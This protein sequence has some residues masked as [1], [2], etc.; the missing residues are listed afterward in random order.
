MPLLL[1]TKPFAP[2]SH[3]VHKY[4]NKQGKEVRVPIKFGQLHSRTLVVNQNIQR[5]GNNHEC[6]LMAHTSM[7]M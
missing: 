6:Q 3:Q 1:A 2:T 7:G 5:F 4:V